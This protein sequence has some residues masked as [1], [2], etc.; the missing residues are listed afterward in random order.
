MVGKLATFELKNLPMCCF[1]VS[2]IT[3]RE[4]ALI[5]VFAIVLTLGFF[6][7]VNTPASE[8]EEALADRRSNF[9]L[10]FVGDN[11]PDDLGDQ[12]QA[13]L[14]KDLR[15]VLES[16]YGV[17]EVSLTINGTR[18]E[19]FEVCEA[20]SRKIGGS[21]VPEG[22]TRNLL[23]VVVGHSDWVGD[24]IKP[25]EAGFPYDTAYITTSD[26]PPVRLYA[27]E[28]QTALRRHFD[29]KDLRVTIV[30]ANCFADAFFEDFTMHRGSWA[31][32]AAC[33]VNELSHS[34][35]QG[36]GGDS[37]RLKRDFGLSVLE[38]LRARAEEFRRGN[39]P[40]GKDVFDDADAAN[41]FSKQ[42]PAY[43]SNVEPF[44]IFNA[45]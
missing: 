36:V 26:E 34:E 6:Q 29:K 2:R 28:F 32:L 41:T 33:G 44:P 21:R 24:R 43:R 42:T 11:R 13:N 19:F 39:C 40:T 9:A 38:S 45:F 8:A 22:R 18:Q 15:E 23:V 4:F 27:P 14:L 17:G 37:T 7:T 5:S 25:E 3:T 12:S 20:M 1:N 10:L 16:E 31:S 30:V 35:R